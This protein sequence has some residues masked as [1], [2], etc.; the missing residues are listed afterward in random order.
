M[1][2]YSPYLLFLIIT[3]PAFS[4][5]TLR[6]KIIDAQSQEPIAFANLATNTGREGTSTDIEGK[7]SFTLPVGYD[8]I[9]LISHVSYTKKVLR[10]S[11][12]KQSFTTLLLQPSEQ[13]LQEVT[14]RAGENPA[15]AIIRKTIQ[16]REKHNP[17]NLKAY[18]Y[19]SYNKVSFE[20]SE[21]DAKTDSI[22]LALLA[23]RDT[24]T[25]KKTEKELLSFDSTARRMHFFMSESV[26]EK[27]V[28]NPQH[29]EERL[30]GLK[31]SGFN[32]PIFAN[33]ATNFQP[34]SF[35]KPFIPLFGKEYS[36]P[37]SEGTFSR[38]TFHLSDTVLHYSDTVYV[39]QFEPKS[40]KNFD[41][42]E[43]Y[44]SIATND[45]AVKNV[46][47]STADPLAKTHI[48]IQQNY[49]KIN[50]YWF[51]VQ[52]NTDLDFKEMKFFGRTTR[53]VHRTF[54]Q[55]ITINPLITKKEFSGTELILEKP[56]KTSSAEILER[57]RANPLDSLEINTYAVL[58]TL[59]EIKQVQKMEKL[60]DALITRTL[61][62]GPL[63]L[64]L[65]KILS[66]N[67]YEG[68]RVGVGISSGS[69]LGKKIRAG[70]YLAYGTKDQAF[71][72]GGELDFLLH[73]R[74]DFHLRFLYQND[75]AEVGSDMRQRI[76]N[77]GASIRTLLGSRF[78]KVINYKALLSYRLLPGLYLEPSLLYQQLTPL[79]D[80]SL[81]VNEQTLTTFNVAETTLSLR[82]L[83]KEQQ[84]AFLGKK[85]PLSTNYP[86]VVFSYTKAVEFLDATIFDY[87]RIN[88]SL[89]HVMR[90]R[91][92]G[93]TNIILS[94]HWL[95]GLAPYNKLATGFGG[96]NES[97]V[98]LDGYFQT[99]D[100]YEFTGNYYAGLFFKHNIGNVLVNTRHSKPELVFYHNTGITD[101]DSERN[102]T[103]P[104]SKVMD[105]GFLESGL[106]L[107]NLYRFNYVDIGY[108]G[109]GISSFYRYG[110]Y[111][112]PKQSDNFVYRLNLSFSF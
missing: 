65:T 4:Q 47:A 73:Q 10:I 38:Y 29:I 33:V 25:L 81:Q 83:H 14:I 51:P 1:K 101:L 98:E 55:D 30:I 85:I 112:L 70:G 45:W 90:L 92:L 64:D 24:A 96:K 27:K 94:T 82:Y 34:F 2:S 105:K 19:I 59:S 20:P 109:I 58:D 12:F 76:Q 72:Y 26:T 77:S 52:L 107:L 8:D 62:I 111:Q 46:V 31:V 42:L 104:N 69:L 67:N 75:I 49:E 61:P 39:I 48:V 100:V 3:I 28:I 63:E 68:A 102:E 57:Y 36:N 97:S 108:M 50:G 95:N 93:K 6:G 9:I 56:E 91:G 110:P 17:E 40:K 35:Y 80:Y 43:G 23:V 99:M 53:L 54:L 18:Q 21:P 44:L 84:L 106:G 71:K 74:K 22:T 11:D 89:K 66:V 15:H 16:H 7:F 32:S 78:D 79:Y 13:T 87:E 86:I 5:T 41:G 37:I 88:F 60:F 103:G